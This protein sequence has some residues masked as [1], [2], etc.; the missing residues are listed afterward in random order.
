M[1]VIFN[2]Q[3]LTIF[4]SFFSLFGIS[5]VVLSDCSHT[6]MF[7]VNPELDWYHFVNPIMLLVLYYT[8]ATLVRLWL[9]EPVNTVSLQTSC[10]IL[11]VRF[12]HSVWKIAMNWCNNSKVING[13][14]NRY[15]NIIFCF[16]SFVFISWLLL[17]CN[18]DLFL[19]LLFNSFA[20]KDLIL[21]TVAI[22]IHDPYCLSSR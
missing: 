19:L 21:F 12:S 18:W 17:L 2:Q 1:I 14:V 10:L 7:K 13:P 9:Q 15:S 20:I 6:W 5:P 22:M 16:W 3:L 4:F 11:R 8:L